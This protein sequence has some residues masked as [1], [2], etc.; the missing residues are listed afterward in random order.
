MKLIPVGT[1]VRITKDSPY[2]PQNFF[3]GD[4][5]KEMLTGK[6]IENDYKSMGDLRYIYR[7][8]WTMD[9]RFHDKN[10][11]RPSDLEVVHN[12]INRMRKEVDLI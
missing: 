2:Y 8:E 7:V 11:Y 12:S 5:S 1:I 10:N 3:N 9:G 4:I 6:V